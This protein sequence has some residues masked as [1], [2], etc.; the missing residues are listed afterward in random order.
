[1]A[2][3]NKIKILMIGPDSQGGITSV[4]KFYFKSGLSDEAFFLPSYTDGNIVHKILF[5][6][7]FLIKY[8]FI[9]VTAKNIS[10]VHI[11]SSQNGSFIRKSI[12]LFIAKFFGKKTIFHIHGGEF[13][14]FYWKSP[15]FI[16]KII[17][18]VLDKSDLILVLSEQW[19][20]IILKMSSNN[21]IKILYNPTIIKESVSSCSEEVNTLFMGRIGTRK[22][23]Y[24]IIEAAKSLQNNNIKIMLY[25]DGEIEQVQKL[26]DKNNLNNKIKIGGWIKGDDI[27]K[28]YNKA[29]I[30]ILPSYNEGL[31]MSV[32]EAMSYGLPVISTPVGGTPEAV[33]DGVNGF[34]IQPGDYKTLAEKID[35][36]ANNKELREQMGVESYKIA[37]E[38]FDINVIIKQLREIYQDYLD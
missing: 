19:K 2:I 11:K 4:I 3:N 13:D 33:E 15:H 14:L 20:K 26:I 17:T 38:K 31:P 23:A 28:A 35:L 37:K 30:F 34:L 5:F 32:L 9:L 25:G 10:I 36:L 24:D 18:N 27:D 29:D 22:G 1:M 12:V 6:S 7:V 21:N 16:K 8:L